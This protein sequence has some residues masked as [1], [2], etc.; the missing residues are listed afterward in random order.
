MTG[1]FSYLWINNF[2]KHRFLSCEWIIKAKCWSTWTIVKRSMIRVN[3]SYCN[4]ILL[5]IISIQ[6]ND[7]F[8][9]SALFGA[10]LGFGMRRVSPENEEMCQS[11][12]LYTSS[13]ASRGVSRCFSRQRWLKIFNF[14]WFL[15]ADSWIFPGFFEKIC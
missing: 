10:H 12:K 4:K 2:V 5:C 15:G 3:L 13:T 8:S 9:I 6:L 14:F 1:I 11:M 7:I